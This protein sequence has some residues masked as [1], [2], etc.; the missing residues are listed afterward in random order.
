MGIQ[1]AGLRSSIVASILAVAAFF[2]T[3]SSPSNLGFLLPLMLGLLV[4]AAAVAAWSFWRWKKSSEVH[5]DSQPDFH[6]EDR[7]SAVLPLRT[8]SLSLGASLGASHAAE[9]AP[10]IVPVAEPALHAS[11]PSPHAPAPRAPAPAQAHV[12]TPEPPR[13]PAKEE[14]PKRVVAPRFVVPPPAAKPSVNDFSTLRTRVAPSAQASALPRVAKSPAPP[15]PA[16]DEPAPYAPSASQRQDQASQP[17]RMA[18]VEPHEDV[19]PQPRGPV[20]RVAPESLVSS[21]FDDDAAPRPLA[22]VNSARLAEQPALAGDTSVVASTPILVSGSVVDA[23][24]PPAALPEAQA[25]ASQPSLFAPEPEAAAPSALPLNAAGGQVDLAALL[26]EDLDLPADWKIKADSVSAAPESESESEPEPESEPQ[27][28]MPVASAHEAAPPAQPSALVMEDIYHIVAR[29]SA[30]SSFAGLQPSGISAESESVADPLPATEA[31]PAS[32]PWDSTE[33]APESEPEPEPVMHTQHEAADEPAFEVPLEVPLDAAAPPADSVEPAAA[34]PP[35]PE[36]PSQPAAPIFAAPP[37]PQIPVRPE[38]FASPVPFAPPAP[39]APRVVRSGFMALGARYPQCHRLSLGI[40]ITIRGLVWR[41][42]TLTE[43]TWTLTVL[44]NGAIINLTAV[45]ALEEELILVN[46]KTGEQ[47]GC[48]VVA[49]TNGDGSRKHVEIEFKQPAPRFWRITFP[50]A[51]W[52]S[53]QR[54]RPS[55]GSSPN[56][57][58]VPEIIRS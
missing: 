14:E 40:P 31:E 6:A 26:F 7:P 57:D 52:S 25:L 10:K 41:D 11:A 42:E 55:S 51:D 58:D 45:V 23:S 13:G 3:A 29:P 43:D 22:V 15:E 19:W 36:A 56:R 49:M 34:A 30:E 38:A 37:A 20:T 18:P 12:P 9:S 27:P 47:V 5:L 39:P 33:P 1:G 32:E 4:L 53:S 54:K 16:R 44:P 17:N 21:P 24:A 2:Q 8:G 28:E 35:W 50:P 48:R 46:N